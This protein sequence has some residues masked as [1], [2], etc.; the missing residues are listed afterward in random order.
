[1]QEKLTRK[2]V[3]MIHNEMNALR[4][5]KLKRILNVVSFL[6]KPHQLFWASP[7][8]AGKDSFS[9]SF[10]SKSSY[11]TKTLCKSY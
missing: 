8:R 3:D 7:V 11:Q 5:K 1:M 2:E 6:H 4:F 9:K 10:M